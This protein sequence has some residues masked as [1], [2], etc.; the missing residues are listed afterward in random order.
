M[1]CV[2]QCNSTNADAANSKHNA[3]KT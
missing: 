1:P 3:H 2:E